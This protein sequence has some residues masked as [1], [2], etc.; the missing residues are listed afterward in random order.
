MGMFDEIVRVDYPLP[1]VGVLGPCYFQTKDIDCALDQFEITS[2]G[3]LIHH[4]R[5]WDIVPE[6]ERSASTGLPLFSERAGSQRVVDRNWCGAL[7]F[8]GDKGAF[9][10]LFDK[11][12]M[13]GVVKH[14]DD[15]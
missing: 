7:H 1:E 15:A 8:Y 6:A 4:Y 14:G 3:R 5:E 9:T 13:V 11:G 10:A 2:G 12:A